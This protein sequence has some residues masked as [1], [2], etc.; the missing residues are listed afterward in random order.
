MR[1][2]ILANALSV[3]AE[4]WARAY[5]ERG[6]ETHVRSIRHAEIPNVTVHTVCVGPV[7]SQSKL[8][9]FLSY[10]RLL[11]VARQHLR[12]IDADVINP[13]Y[14]ITHGAISVFSGIHPCVISVWGKDV[15]WDGRGKM[16]IIQTLLNRYALNGVDL[17]CSTSEYMIKH[18]RTFVS[19]DRE[20][21]HIPFGVDIEHFYPEESLESG[22]EGDSFIIG[23]VKRLSPKYGPDVLVRAMQKIVRSCPDARL[24]MAGRGPLRHDLEKLSYDLGV[25]DRIDFLEFVP[26]D[27]VAELMRGLDVFVNCSVARSESF[28]VAI[29]G[30][31]HVVCPWS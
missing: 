3:H 5:A 12:E 26:H 14:R 25:K 8:W 20:I 11:L 31:R 28:G 30:R 13:H 10:F 22:S 9:T 7:N 19:A 15:I 4:R 18:A 17:I 21:V 2:C 16:P 24:V 1:I 23:F 6:H 29:L 27:E